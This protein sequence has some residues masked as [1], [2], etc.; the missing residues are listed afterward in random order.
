[1]VL[2]NTGFTHKVENWM[3]GTSTLAWHLPDIR[4]W[5]GQGG[6]GPYCTEVS[7]TIQVCRLGAIRKFNPWQLTVVSAPFSTLP[8]LPS[9]TF[10]AS[11]RL[12]LKNRWMADGVSRC[13]LYGLVNHRYFCAKAHLILSDDNSSR[14]PRGDQEL[15]APD[16]QTHSALTA[17]RH[18]TSGRHARLDKSIPLAE[19]DA[20]I[21]DYRDHLLLLR[22]WIQPLAHWLETFSDGPQSAG[23]FPCAPYVALI[24][25]DL[26]DPA[27][28]QGG[29]SHAAESPWPLGASSAYRWGA[30]Y[31]V[32][33]S[34]LGGAV[35]YRRL[36][37]RLAP[38]PMRYLLGEG[39]PGERWKRF[40]FALNGTVV[41]RP[42]IAD[43][44]RGACEAFDRLI[45]LKQESEVLA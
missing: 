12:T 38:H 45:E 3:S 27:M 11:F 44:C 36:R 4:L 19:P 21:V 23:F 14:Q 24:E 30:C 26:A 35:L 13:S 7:W 39:Q 33:G 8:N 25:Q 41:S 40:V 6:R 34:Q 18:A 29:C 43:A 2:A 10:F 28:P 16:T 17:L 42:E 5:K 31:V 22:A 9:R 1:M 32:E 37:Q 15:I 20:G